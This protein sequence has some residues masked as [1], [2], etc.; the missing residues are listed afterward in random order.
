MNT[1]TLCRKVIDCS[2]DESYLEQPAD[3]DIAGIGV[4]L[5]FFVPATASVFTFALAY[6]SRGLPPEQYTHVDEVLMSTLDF[7][8]SKFFSL[9]GLTPRPKAPHN[10]RLSGYQIFLLALSDQL[11]VTGVGLLIS[12]YSQMCSLSAFSFHV[13]IDLVFLCQTVYLITLA[14]LKEHFIQNP[15]PAKLRVWILLLYLVLLYGTIFLQYITLSYNPYH[16]AACEIR[17]YQ[18]NL[19]FAVWD[20]G[21]WAWVTFIGYYSSVTSH[22]FPTGPDS[23]TMVFLSMLFAGSDSRQILDDFVAEEKQKR[24]EK[25]ARKHQALLTITQH[26]TTGKPFRMG[27]LVRLM[28]VL[29]PEIFGELIASMVYELANSLFWYGWGIYYLA[30]ELFYDLADISP[31]LDMKFGQVMPL[32]LLLVYAI[33]AVEAKASEKHDK[34]KDSD[35]HNKKE[36]ESEPPHTTYTTNV[37]MSPVTEHPEHNPIQHSFTIPVLRRRTF[38]ATTPAAPTGTA[39]AESSDTGS[40]ELRSIQSR[41]STV[42]LERAQ[43][44]RDDDELIDVFALAREGAGIYVNVAVLILFFLLIGYLLLTAFYMRY[45]VTALATLFSI[46]FIIKTGIAIRAV[47]RLKGERERCYGPGGGN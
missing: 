13:V 18:Q 15:K 16:L 28:F 46:R 19:G 24:R 11:L 21:T 32:I 35:P 41:M 43:T 22:L 33:A 1:V 17:Y 34:N 12:L 10:G 7:I 2:A 5:A 9:L 40:I 39:Q 30:S 45:M 38:G 6:I 47:R 26:T 20:W 29:G 4:L 37:N 44:I 31:L 23:W 8:K 42:Q 3:P 25:N 36:E 14:A 27:I